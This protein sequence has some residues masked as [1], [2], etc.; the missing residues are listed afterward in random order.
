M[1]PYVRVVANSWLFAPPQQRLSDSVGAGLPGTKT[2]D[3]GKFTIEN[4]AVT[5]R[6]TAD[7]RV[8]AIDDIVERAVGHCL[9]DLRLRQEINPVCGTA[10]RFRV[11]FLASKGIQ[12]GD[13]HAMRAERGHRFVHAFEFEQLDDR[14]GAINA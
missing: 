8:G 3:R 1:L 10:V 4:I 12:L 5:D 7:G 14:A 11:T 6:A 13:S 9:F 2:L